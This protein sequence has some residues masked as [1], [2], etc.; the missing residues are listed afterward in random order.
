MSSFTDLLAL[1]RVD[2]DIFTGSCHAGA[3]L[4]VFGGHV[5][6]Q[7]LTAAG[8]TVEDTQRKLDSLHAYFLR[9]GRTTDPIVYL[10]DRPR[11]GRSFTTRRVQAV[12]Y[13][14]TIFVL[15]ASFAISEDGPEHQPE[16]PHVPAPD[17]CPVLDMRW[18]DA[19]TED[20]GGTLIEAREIP[21]DAVR[22]DTDGRFE[23]GLWV[24]VQGAMPADQ[25][26][27]NCALTYISDLRLAGAALMKHGG[28]EANP[29][30]SITSLDH[31]MWFHRDFR[32][33][34]WLL[35]VHG[36]PVA[37]GGRGLNLGQFFT[38]DGTLVASAV[39][40]SLMRRLAD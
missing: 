29:G 15:S 18:L 23:G 13:G 14:V 37:G 16:A 7:A 2:R 22:D 3:P 4:R 11:D 38:A 6:A 5:A 40:E 12:Q 25:R 35:F 31:A 19:A 1:E 30:M 10:V 27:H 17:D 32:A 8:I 9:P 28:Y 20:A 24:R 33:D 34:E 21:A 39:Q 26:V 36:S